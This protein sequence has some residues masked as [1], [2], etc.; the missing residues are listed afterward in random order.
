MLQEVHSHFF[1]N[2]HNKHW[3]GQTNL[4]FKFE[5]LDNL[6]YSQASSILAIQLVWAKNLRHKL[7]V[8]TSFLQI[9]C[10]LTRKSVYGSK[11]KNL[12]EQSRDIRSFFQIRQIKFSY[13]KSIT[14]T[15]N[16]MSLFIDENRG[17]L[18]ES[19]IIRKSQ[20][21]Q[22]THTISLSDFHPFLPSSVVSS[23]MSILHS[24]SNSPFR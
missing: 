7:A 14:V 12:K 19:F 9:I 4:V 3:K 2:I 17:V 22:V 1:L 23:S 16:L 18:S 5:L 8:V 6:T 11:S 10:S 20:V 15:S 21:I 13:M 24:R